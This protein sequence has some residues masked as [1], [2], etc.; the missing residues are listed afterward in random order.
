[1]AGAPECGS[2]LRVLTMNIWFSRHQYTRRMAAI[3]DLIATHRP[4]VIAL[5]ELTDEHFAALRAQPALATYSFTPPP[6]GGSSAP[7]TPCQLFFS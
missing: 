1:M 3:A 6:P 4:H 2:L 5:Q 7:R